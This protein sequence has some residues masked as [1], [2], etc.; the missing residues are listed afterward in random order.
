MKE[1]VEDLKVEQE[2]LD[3]F[4]S[5]L[6]EKDW[7]RMTPA[8]GWTIRDSISH[9]AYI[10]EVAVAAV[11]GDN[12]PFELAFKIGMAFNEEGPK[13]GRN[14][15]VNELLKWWWEARNVMYAEL[16]KL[17]PKARIPWFALPMGARAF[18]TARL[19]ETWAHGLDCYDAM[20][21]SPLDTDRLRHV[22]FLG[23]QA[24]PYAYT[25]HELPAPDKPL[26]LELVLPS[27]KMWTQGPDGSENVI[28]GSAGDFCRVAV[29]RRH[30]QDTA[31]EIK[32]DEALR[33]VE[34]AQTFAGPSGSGRKPSQTT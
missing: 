33:F 9:I 26:R 23:Y 13:K 14:M 28:R 18:A 15:K 20:G 25:V 3:K 17:D 16:I 2:S 19:M 1:I 32:G 7:D 12:S 27:G 30:W 34:I 10:D 6:T 29:R 24:R 21:I 5:T 8:E 31:L 11:H 22:A 4:V